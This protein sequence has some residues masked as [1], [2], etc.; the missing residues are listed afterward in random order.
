MRI[1]CTPGVAL[2]E[3][4]WAGNNNSLAN[5]EDALMSPICKSI[6]AL[7]QKLKVLIAFPIS[8]SVFPQTD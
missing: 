3:V 5:K 7:P 8:Q 6:K 1:K 2:I 4:S